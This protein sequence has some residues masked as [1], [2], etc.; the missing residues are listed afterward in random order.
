MLIVYCEKQLP[1]ICNDVWQKPALTPDPFFHWVGC[2]VNNIRLTGRCVSKGCKKLIF[3]FF[4]N[5]ISFSIVVISTACAIVIYGCLKSLILLPP[6]SIKCCFA[7]SA[8]SPPTT[9]L[10]LTQISLE[11]REPTSSQSKPVLSLFSFLQTFC[12]CWRAFSN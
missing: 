10:I 3:F 1:S 6:S 9:I 5:V 8:E 12:E 7:A 4:S 2:M 11:S